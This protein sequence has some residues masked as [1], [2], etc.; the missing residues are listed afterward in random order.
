MLPKKDG[1]EVIKSLRGRNNTVP[2]LILTAKDS[3]NDKV[4]GLDL[5]ADDYLTKPF[6]LEELFARIRSLLRR[7]GLEKTN[8]LKIDDLELDTITHIAKR[9]YRKIELTAR[10]YE[11]LE[12]FLRNK[13]RVLTRSIIAQHVWEYNF[14]S[15]S[16]IVDVYIN[17]L[18]NKIDDQHL[19][20]L[21]HSI[22]GVGYILKHDEDKR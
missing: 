3:I 8:I 20:K 5:G 7:Q 6:V 16:N 17:R 13:N 12:F 2:I 22:K 15:E 14:D 4:T 1:L 11:L 21:I 9:G 10:E 18:R 19:P